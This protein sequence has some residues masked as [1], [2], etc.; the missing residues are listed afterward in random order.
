M[1][2]K[3]YG[4]FKNR[5]GNKI[6]VIG[7]VDAVGPNKDNGLGK[8]S[9]TIDGKNPKRWA[10]GFERQIKKLQ[11]SDKSVFKKMANDTDI[12]GPYPERDQGKKGR[13]PGKGTEM[14]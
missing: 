12:I 5:H 8:I 14:E 10:S 9:F 3:D 13:T 7:G 11:D 2:R 6:R 1:K 4:I